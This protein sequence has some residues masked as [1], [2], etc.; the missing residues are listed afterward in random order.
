ML[1]F[2]SAS[3]ESES[4]SV[5]QPT[6]TAITAIRGILAIIHTAITAGIL[7]T[8][9]TITMGVRTTGLI[10]TIAII[11]TATKAHALVKGL[12]SW[13]GVIHS[14]PAFFYPGLIIPFSLRAVYERIP[15]ILRRIR[16]AK[17]QM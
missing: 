14:K 10:V 6:G 17:H 2:Q 13:L 5:T 12:R 4:G 16:F 15:V 11:I 3:A 9:R 8:E 7:I 1:R